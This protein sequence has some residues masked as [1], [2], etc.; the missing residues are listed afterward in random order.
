MSRRTRAAS[1]E[2]SRQRRVPGHGVAGAATRTAHVVAGAEALERR[3]MLSNVWPVGPEVRIDNSASEYSRG[4][5]VDSDVD[6]NFVVAWESDRDVFA[7]RYSAAGVPEV[8][9]VPIAD[10]ELGDDDR[11]P[12]PPA[13]RLPERALGGTHPVPLGGVEAVDAEVERAAHG[14]DELRLLDLPVAAADLPAAEADRR[15]L[16]SRPSEWSPLHGG[17]PPGYDC[18][19]ESAGV[20]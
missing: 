10:A 4:A 8:R 15:D 20:A 19:R 18:A 6:G 12:A 2:S 5:V 11:V 16:E 1:A 17:P 7:R 3:V 9:L 13:E 14:A